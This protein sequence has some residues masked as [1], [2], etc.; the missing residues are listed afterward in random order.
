MLLCSNEFFVA[1]A[2]SLA[3]QQNKNSDSYQ[4]RNQDTDDERNNRMPT[5]AGR[6]VREPLA[7]ERVY[8][9]GYRFGGTGSG[10]CRTHPYLFTD[11]C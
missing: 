7:P 6:S 8:R 11:V 4:H 1:L 9:A 5:P 10:G 3:D 2:S